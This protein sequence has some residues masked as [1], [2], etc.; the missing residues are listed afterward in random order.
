MQHSKVYRIIFNTGKCLHAP[1]RGKLMSLLRKHKEVRR[2]HLFL[3]VDCYLHFTWSKTFVFCQLSQKHL[4][5]ATLSRNNWVFFKRWKISLESPA[6]FSKWQQ[7]AFLNRF[8]WMLD[9]LHRPFRNFFATLFI[10]LN[11]I[12]KCSWLP[13][14]VISVVGISRRLKAAYRGWLKY[15]FL[16]F[17]FVDDWWSEKAQGIIFK[18]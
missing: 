15:R 14:L 18:L 3:V 9:R 11:V 13:L 6:N 8:K 2:R 16:S 7:G 5:Y 1:Q 10:I 17:F 12:K 4:Y